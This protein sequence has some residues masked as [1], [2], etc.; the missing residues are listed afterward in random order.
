MMN[1]ELP[2]LYIKSGCPWCQEAVE[3]LMSN[4][5]AY[6]ETN[7]TTDAPAFEEMKRKSGQSKAPTLDWYGQILPDFGVEELK[8]FLLQQN[9]EFEDS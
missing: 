8:A 2:I 7:V 4:G 9:V 5:I 1:R 6:H 3:F